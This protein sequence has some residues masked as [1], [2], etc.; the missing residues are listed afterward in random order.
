MSSLSPWSWPSGINLHIQAEICRVWLNHL[1]K[2]TTQMFTDPWQIDD[3]SLGDSWCMRYK[4]LASQCI[5]TPPPKMM[6]WPDPRCNKQTKNARNGICLDT[7]EGGRNLNFTAS[8][9]AFQYWCLNSEKWTLLFY[10][11]V[12]LWTITPAIINS[13]GPSIT[14][15]ITESLLHE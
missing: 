13:V 8:R 6:H 9:G 5:L 15:S 4:G 11:V 7:W 10:L 2:E 1:S 3:N 14:E 12:K